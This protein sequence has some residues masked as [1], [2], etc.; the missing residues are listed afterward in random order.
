MDASPL[1]CNLDALS[2]TERAHHA[3]TLH[4]LGEK[5]LERKELPDGYA[6]RFAWESDILE[7]FV[8]WIP[9][10]RACCPF[11]RFSIEVEPGNAVWLRLTGSAEVKE[12]IRF[13]FQK[14]GL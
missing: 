6:Y 13:E 9:L 5:I 8:E 12:F 2:P 10:E 1:Q 7:Q 14:L 3:A 4:K 11:L